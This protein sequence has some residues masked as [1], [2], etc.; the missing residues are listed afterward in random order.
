KRD[1]SSDVCSSDLGDPEWE[2]PAKELA[3]KTYEI[4]Q[5]LVDVLGIEDVGATFRGKV[6]Y[7]PSC[8]MTRIL[9]IKDAPKKLLKNVK[10]IDLV[11][12]PLGEDCCGFGGTIA[13]KSPVISGEMVKEKSGHVAE[14]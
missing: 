14:T 5:F 9:G 10:G 12:L 11:E 1:W 7:H 13:V 8:H 2:E 6:T 4:T 3:G